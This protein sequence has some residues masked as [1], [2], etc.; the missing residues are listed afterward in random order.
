MR[1]SA[2]AGLWFLECID[3]VNRA[4][5]GTHELEQMMRDVLDVVLDVFQS[6]RAFLITTPADEPELFLPAIE[7]T[8]AAYPGLGPGQALAPSPKLIE[9]HAKAMAAK[10]PVA[11]G[12]EE[13]AGTGLT[14]QLSVRSLLVTAIHPKQMPPY[15]FG[16]H[17]CSKPRVWTRDERE[18]LAEIGERIAVALNAL[19]LFREL[20]TSENRLAAAEALAH[21]GYWE[22]DLATNRVSLSPESRLIFGD[23]ETR[24]QLRERIH[25]EDRDR[26][27]AGAREQLLAGKVLD[28]EAR[29]TRPD[30]AIRIVHSRIQLL[31]GP[32][33]RPRSFF[34][35]AHDVT[36]TRAAEMSQHETEVRFRAIVDHASDALF[37][38]D[39]NARVI[40]VNDRACES[41]GYSRDEL[42][43]A[44]PAEFDLSATPAFAK[45]LAARF[46]KEE[47]IVFD[48]IHRRKDGSEFPVEVRMRRF[49][50][51]ERRTVALAR[52]ITERKRAEKLLR[53][54]E[55]RFRSMI[56]N[57]SDLISV[58]NRDGIFQFQSPASLRMLGYPPE[59]LIGKPCMDYVHPADVA[60]KLMALDRAL[61]HPGTP[62]TVEQRVRRAD[63]QWRV[64]QTTAQSL[65]GG[66]EP[67]VVLNSRDLTDARQLE[68]QLRQAQ[69]MEAIGQ[70]AGGVA[71]D[72]NNILA[73]IMM[74]TGLSN[75]PGVPDE[76]RENLEQIQLAA[77]RAA[78]LT[79]QLLMF[80]RRQMMQPRDVDLNELVKSLAKML[81]R[82]IGETVTLRLDLDTQ[83]L[84]TRVDPGMMDQLLMNL[85]I[86]SRDAMPTGGTLVIQTRRV[87]GSIAIRVHDTGIGIE[88]EVLPRIFEPFFTTKEAG[89]GT[90][91][92]LATV[93]GIVQQHHGT[94]D[95]KSEPNHGTTFTVTLPI[96]GSGHAAAVTSQAPPRGANELVLV[97]ED[98]ASVRRIIRRTLERAGYRVVD[99]A[100]GREAIQTWRGLADKPAL[101]L[102][103]LVM[104]GLGGHQ[105]AATL[106][107]TTP[108][109]RVLY[110]SGYS[111]E[112]A[113]KELELRSGENFVQKP[114]APAALLEAVRRC[115]DA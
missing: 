98:D 100:N 56:E 6:D 85:A 49:W 26:V 5:Q 18:L 66:D 115:L 90:G 64:F 10:E 92:G 8:T 19:L 89:K 108:A 74:Q 13:L 52:D 59:A 27:V 3:R 28:E 78:E 112:N 31:R 43:G 1:N 73:A 2:H 7:R 77:E 80:S 60:K 22:I 86:N 97:V 12:E 109:L 114:F 25:P 30:G 4:I 82:I 32:D 95:V 104:P 88:P 47:T 68:E 37:L 79:R 42:V 58:I 11:F 113:G 20:S 23:V 9:A 39:A 96:G 38:M 35:T 84:V 75:V 69:K 99:A 29:V 63:G 24:D 111:A 41:L 21:I 62:V 93:F 94:I 67:M 54:S 105:V 48:S 81:L 106:R 107:E 101:L 44:A 61:A 83:P 51:G 33:G 71:H 65:P 87:A 36:E 45:E 34:A 72:F 102:T 103:D 17:Q 14:E 40:E 46:T 76:V 50:D 110:T 53:D 57:A 91:L 70:L 15:V 55:Q 16:L